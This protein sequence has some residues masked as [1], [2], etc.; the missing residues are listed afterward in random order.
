MKQCVRCWKKLDPEHKL[1][2]DRCIVKVN[3]EIQWKADRPYQYYFR[4]NIKRQKHE[5]NKLSEMLKA[6]RTEGE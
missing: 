5:N 3:E 2:C 1:R 4:F 6:D